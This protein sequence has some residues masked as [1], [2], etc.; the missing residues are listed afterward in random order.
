MYLIT[1]TW[2]CSI[3]IGPSPLRLRS[4]VSGS[5]SIHEVTSDITKVFSRIK[6]ELDPTADAA[7]LLIKLVV[8]SDYA[9]FEAVHISRP[10]KSRPLICV[11]WQYNDLGYGRFVEIFCLDSRLD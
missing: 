11:H 2:A 4:S 9:G 6:R 10:T 7:T 8:G 1:Y 5:D 3:N